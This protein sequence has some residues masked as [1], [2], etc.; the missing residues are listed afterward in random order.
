LLH[1]YDKDFSREIFCWQSTL[2]KIL[3]SHIVGG[4]RFKSAKNVSIQS[5]RLE[6]NE[7]R[8]Y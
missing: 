6:E 8:N 3:S 7:L 1:V 5:P 2:L 4:K